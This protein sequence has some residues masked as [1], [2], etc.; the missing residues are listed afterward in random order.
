M[1]R[2]S[3]DSGVVASNTVS[4]V[5]LFAFFLSLSLLWSQLHPRN[6]NET[7]AAIMFLCLLFVL[8]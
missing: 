3:S 1:Y 8:G 5:N 4:V 7:A 2:M 6:L